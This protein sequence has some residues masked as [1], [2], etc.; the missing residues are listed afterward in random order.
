MSVYASVISLHAFTHLQMRPSPER[1]RSGPF[2]ALGIAAGR[3]AELLSKWHVN[4]WV[5]ADI[6]G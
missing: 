3:D 5:L 6:P 2:L 4:V 1:T